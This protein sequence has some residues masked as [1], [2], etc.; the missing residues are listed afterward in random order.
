MGGPG[1][2]EGMEVGLEFSRQDRTWLSSTLSW[3]MGTVHFFVPHLVPS[4]LADL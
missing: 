3:S 2:G 1:A 4:R